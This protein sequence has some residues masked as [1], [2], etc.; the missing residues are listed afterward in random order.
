M[1]IAWIIGFSVYFYRKR[2]RRQLKAKVSAGLAKPKEKKHKGPEEKIIIPPDPAVILGHRLPGENAFS[3]GKGNGNGNRKHSKDNGEGPFATRLSSD[4]SPEDDKKEMSVD[5]HHGP[6]ET[7]DP[8]VEISEK[9]TV[10]RN[11]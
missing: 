7:D 6:P 8:A 3:N 1:G 5:H 11:V 2:K 9:M 4:S 10:P